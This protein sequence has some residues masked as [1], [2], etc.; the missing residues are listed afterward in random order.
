MT[1]KMREVGKDMTF[2][3]YTLPWFETLLRELEEEAVARG[4]SDPELAVLSG[5]EAESADNYVQTV[6][7]A[8][9]TFSND[10]PVLWRIN[11][12]AQLIEPSEQGLTVEVS[13]DVEVSPDATVSSDTTVSS[14]AEISAS[15]V[16]AAS[17]LI[18]ATEDDFSI[19][20][21]PENA[22]TVKT[23]KVDITASSIAG[24]TPKGSYGLIVES[25]EDGE[26]WE[27]KG[28]LKMDTSDNSGNSSHYASSSSG[29]CDAGVS[30][31]GIVMLLSALILKRKTR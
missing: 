21:N 26:E 16:S 13:S 11:G 4:E 9:E 29:G 8:S 19:T 15:S 27:Q 14:D 3:S 28:V 31:S 24:V 30:V 5:S 23:D 12:V 17:S 10:V 25:S 1:D 18:T 22:G 20:L 2:C 6:I 7:T